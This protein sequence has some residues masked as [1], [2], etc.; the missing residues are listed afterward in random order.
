V[1]KAN[2]ISFLYP[3]IAF[4]LIIDMCIFVC[5]NLSTQENPGK[6]VIAQNTL[7]IPEISLLSLENPGK[8]K[9]SGPCDEGTPQ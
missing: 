4:R 5:E 7:E 2:I 1:I 3:S 9:Y 6:N 8:H